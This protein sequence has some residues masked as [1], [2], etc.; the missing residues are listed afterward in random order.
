MIESGLQQVSAWVTD[1]IQ[2]FGNGYKSKRRFESNKKIPTVKFPINFKTQ[3]PSFQ[4]P[5]RISN[6]S[7]LTIESG[8][9]RSGM[10]YEK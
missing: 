4:Q 1:L 3:A 7:K 10:K 9:R 2:Q 5:I 8:D 6:E